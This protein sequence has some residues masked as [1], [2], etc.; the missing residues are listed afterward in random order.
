V[1]VVQRGWETSEDNVLSRKK[2][3]N[4]GLAE[5]DR[6]LFH[7]LSHATG[8]KRGN[9]FADEDHNRKRELNGIG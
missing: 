5:F 9:S 3:I 2:E 1:D 7:P 4:K 6:I 8:D